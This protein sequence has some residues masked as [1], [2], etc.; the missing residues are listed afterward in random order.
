M[1]KIV[2][3]YDGSS[4]A[5]RALDRV[6]EL[7]AGDGEVVVVCAADLPTQTEDPVWGVPSGD[8][9][10]A[11]WLRE[12]LSGA[13]ERLRE[14]GVSARTAEGYGD[15][16]DAV[17]RRAADEGA[18]LVVVGTRGLNFAERALLGSVSTKIVHHAPCDVLVVH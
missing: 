18:D 14:R 9:G 2:V 7:V 3:A 11:E 17:V 1:K 8:P 12:T 6:A 4:H 10:G 13:R 16:A 15:A 5:D